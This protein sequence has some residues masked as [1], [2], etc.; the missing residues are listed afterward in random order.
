[1]ISVPLDEA[2]FNWLCSQV[3]QVQ[4][5][6]T[7]KTYRRLL[8]LLYQKEYIWLVPNDDNRMADGRALR[9]E[10]VGEL[11]ISNVDQDWMSLDCSF[12]EMLLGISRRASFLD[13]GT[14]AEWFWHLLQNIELHVFND[15]MEIN[16]NIVDDTL[17]RVI[18]RHY[19]P[20]GRGGL[21]PLRFSAGDQRKLELW[22]QMNAYLLENDR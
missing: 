1:M 10:F 6:E 3:G 19:E 17:E 22:C 13:D 15:R 18:W 7:S 8:R 14:P 9:N 20:T 21:F 2:Y 5:R 4:V 11:H 16:E 12:F